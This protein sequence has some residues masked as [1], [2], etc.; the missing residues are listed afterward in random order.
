MQQITRKADGSAALARGDTRVPD[1]PAWRYQLVGL[2]TSL[3]ANDTGDVT[4]FDYTGATALEQ[5]AMMY[6]ALPK[7]DGQFYIWRDIDGK[8]IKPNS[9]KAWGAQN[10]ELAD[11]QWALCES[12]GVTV[13]EAMT[14]SLHLNRLQIRNKDEGFVI[15]DSIYCHRDLA[16]DK[17]VVMTTQ[18]AKNLIKNNLRWDELT[19]LIEGL[20]LDETAYT[21]PQN[22]FFN[23]FFVPHGDFPYQDFCKTSANFKSEILP[24]VP[25]FTRAYLKVRAHWE[26]FDRSAYTTPLN[27]GIMSE[28]EQADFIEKR[29][30][31]NELLTKTTNIEENWR[32]VVPPHTRLEDYEAVKAIL[33]YE[34]KF[35]NLFIES[36]DEVNIKK[37]KTDN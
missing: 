18:Q 12:T 28:Q 16:P 32:Q 9:G 23:F 27:F 37:R 30:K 29:R 11:L 14:P 7:S 17:Q 25:F 26:F 21:R 13:Q 33:P 1:M 36:E 31:Y 20:P 34:S 6:Q 35:K 19:Y 22:E 4:F 3:P 10:Q 8:L 15:D 24:I 2:H 5:R